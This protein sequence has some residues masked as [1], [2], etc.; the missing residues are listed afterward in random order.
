MKKIMNDPAAFVDESLAGI[1][2]AHGDQLAFAPGDTR[3]VICKDAPVDGKVT[4][5]T[6]GGYGHLPTFLGFVGKGFCD[7]V[8]VG[9]VFTSPSS[10]AILNAA[11]AAHGGKGVLF[12]FG[13]YMGDTMNFEMASEMLE[14]EDIPSQIIKGSDDVASAPRDQWESRRGVAGIFFAYKIAGAMADTGASLEEVCQVT[15]RACARIATMGVA[16]SSCQLPGAQS[17]IFEMHDDDMEIGMGIHGEPGVERGVMKTS[18]EIAQVLTQKVSEDLSL[19]QGSQVALLVNGLGATSREEL[20][21]LYHDVKKIMDQQG[22]CVKRVFV[23]EFATSLEMQG[24]SLT[25]FHLDPQLED[26]L[27]KPGRT[28]FVCV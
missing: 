16:F 27:N 17:P 26:L 6:G 22:I 23:G 28:P 24:A 14:F 12:L 20:Y 4:I 15:R 5:I 19:A 11:K 2:A 9:N 8:A 25:A 1:M 21:L 3:A 13:N 7:G 18:A 10:E